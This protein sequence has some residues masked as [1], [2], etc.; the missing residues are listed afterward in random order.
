VTQDVIG[1]WS[2][3][4]CGARLAYVACEGSVAVLTQKGQRAAA[5][6]E[7]LRNPWNFDRRT[8]APAGA[9]EGIDAKCH[10]PASIVHL[11][12]QP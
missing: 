6:G 9:E 2:L 12:H 1:H 3:V 11:T 7:V 8:T 10:P 5:T 4:I